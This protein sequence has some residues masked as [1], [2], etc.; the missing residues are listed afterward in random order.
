[1]V[2]NNQLYS[3]QKRKL[4]RN[5][6]GF[7]TRF[8]TERANNQFQKMSPEVANKLMESVDKPEFQN[9]L[10]HLFNIDVLQTKLVDWT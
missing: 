3:N 10:N 6:E 9:I 1:M 4:V 2:N 8:I 7:E 5:S